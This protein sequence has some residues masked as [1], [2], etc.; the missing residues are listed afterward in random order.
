MEPN[1]PPSFTGMDVN[2]VNQP[3]PAGNGMG[4]IIAVIVAIILLAGVAYAGWIYTKIDNTV[5]PVEVRKEA[6]AAVAEIP[7]AAT[8]S[9]SDSLDADLDYSGSIDYSQ[10]AAAIDTE[11]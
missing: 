5:Q 10:D 2:K 9:S 1:N 7:V 3:Q 6:P 8:T 4:K 11:F